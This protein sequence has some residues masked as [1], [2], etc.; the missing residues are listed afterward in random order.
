MQKMPL[1]ADKPN[2]PS[3]K[4]LSLTGCYTAKIVYMLFI[5]QHFFY[6][7]GLH[8]GLNVRSQYMCHAA[9]SH[10][11]YYK[12]KYCTAFPDRQGDIFQYGCISNNPW[13]NKSPLLYPLVW[14]IICWG[15]AVFLEKH[16][17][18]VQI[19]GVEQLPSISVDDALFARFCV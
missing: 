1:S 14:T 9:C 18:N 8:Q 3:A 13:Y 2:Q 15:L 4:F 12:G 6:M 16:R 17:T 11:I 7:Q 5:W 10:F 19:N